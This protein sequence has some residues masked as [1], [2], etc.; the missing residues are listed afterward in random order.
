V[1]RVVLHPSSFLTWF[2]GDGAHGSLRSEYEAGALDVVVPPTF[3]A[4]TMAV[5]A[6]A[7]WPASR[8]ARVAVEIDRLAFRSQDPPP[9][10]LAGWLGRG[11]DASPAGYAALAEA[12][13][14]PLA[15][16]DESLRAATAARPRADA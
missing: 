7:G 6:T 16:A 4:D 13:D 14:L 2:E 9:D 5:L 3:V 15:V 12:L 1:R 8:L 11:L 10:A